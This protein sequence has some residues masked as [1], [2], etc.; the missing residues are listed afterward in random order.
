MIR[1]I[2]VSVLGLGTV[3]SGGWMETFDEG[4]GDWQYVNIKDNGKYKS[5]DP[6]YYST[7]GNDGGYIAAPVSTSP[8]DQ[9]KGNLSSVS[10]K[11]AFS[12]GRLYS[13]ETSN[14]SLSGDWTGGTLTIDTLLL[15]GTITGPGKTP[16]ARF[17]LGSGGNG[18]PYYVSNDL[19]SWDIHADSKWTTHQVELREENFIA[20][21]TL[22][23]SPSFANIISNV[24]SFG[25]LF[26][27]SSDTFNDTDYLGITSK[28]STW[29]GIDNVGV[30]GNGESD[31]PEAP[32]VMLAGIGFLL[33]FR[34]GR[35][36]IT[37][38]AA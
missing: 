18:Q 10:N 5:Y 6:F 38:P 27:D 35:P 24:K 8:S 16:T 12:K 26:T 21:P 32:A 14:T 17:F 15:S 2:I 1:T 36:R 4:A 22:K 9:N 19:F 31:I 29:V 33:M 28:G 30:Y 13:I 25:I 34:K 11:A 20:W 7:K 23:S 37:S 3:A